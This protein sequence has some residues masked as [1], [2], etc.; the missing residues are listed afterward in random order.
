MI[1]SAPKETLSSVEDTG[2]IKVPKGGAIVI[3]RVS[4]RTSGDL[5]VNTREIF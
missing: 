4:E 3:G 5:F 1:V 2:Y